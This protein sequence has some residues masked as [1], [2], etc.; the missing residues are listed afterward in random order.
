VASILAAAAAGAAPIAHAQQG[1]AAAAGL[2]EIVVTARRQTES[3]IEVPV[4]ITVLTQQDITQRGIE[5]LQDVALFTPGLTYFDSI[6]NQLGTPVIRGISQTNLNSPDRNVAIFYGGVYL[7]NSNASNLEMLDL[8]RIEVVKGP[9]SALYGRNAFMGAINYVPAAPTEELMA[10]VEGTLGS[11][12]REEIVFKLAGPITDTLG[13]RV[14]ASYN[15]FDGTWKN[16]GDPGDNLGGFETNNVSGMLEWDPTDRFEA[17]LF[18]YYTDDVRDSSPQYFVDLNCGPTGRPLSAVCGDMPIDTHLAA[19]PDSLAFSRQVTL[20][21]LDLSYDFGPV[22]LKGQFAYYDAKTDNF[23]DYASGAGDGAGETFS[24]VNRAA[25]AVIL[26]RQAVPYFTGAG[27]GESDS[28]S[29]ELRLESRRDRELRWMIG[30]FYFDNEAL[31]KSKFAFDG[32]ELNPGEIPLDAFFLGGRVT[33]YDDPRGNMVVLSKDLREDEQVSVFGSLAW[34]VTDSLT[35]SAELRYD[36][37]DRSRE[38]PLIGAS[39]HQEDTFT[40]DT[41]RFSGEYAV[42]PVQRLYAS[43]AK[44]VISGYFNPTF[45]AAAQRP[46]PEALQAYDPAENITYELGWKAEWLDGRVSTDLALF[47]ID[48][49][50]IQI[51]VTPPQDSGLISN[52]IQNIGDATGTGFELA[53]NFQATDHLRAGFTYSYSP[54]EFDDG[55][56]DPGMT[57]Y[58]GGAAGLAAG[59]C[60]S[61]T[62]RGAVLPD[63]S[64]EPLNRSAEKLASAYAMYDV[65]LGGDWSAYAR[66]DASYTG[67]IPHYTL[68]LAYWASRTL[69]NTRLG[70]RRGPLEIAVWAHNLTDEEYVAAAI[71]QPPIAPPLRFVPNPTMG[72][73]RTYG[74]T[75]SYTF[76]SN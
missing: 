50:D 15:S 6:Q 31:S 35:L 60:P 37:E 12:E 26:R 67:D 22:A 74:L 7:A 5:N 62:F 23:S 44:G 16:Y 48:Y 52:L 33:V 36:E 46:V 59:F 39:S 54:T 57:R 32:R 72:Q 61:L 56:P 13:G 17:R 65:P 69:M 76:G 49:T 47:Y 10:F 42:T 20:G 51:N 34:D 25:P 2:D 40:Y 14:A 43:A 21:S 27:Q 8:E 1:A 19:D 38:N 18:G 53:V 24:I 66:V 73:G 63:V 28:S 30:A 3:L 29:A 55:T 75:A 64:G 70:V 58:C 45:D 11:D 68:P 9:Q 41:W 71:N 4:A